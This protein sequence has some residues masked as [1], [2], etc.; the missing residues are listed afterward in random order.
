MQV[1]CSF[2]DHQ[3]TQLKWSRCINT[4]GFRGHNVSC[5][6]YLEHLNRTLKE[7]IRGLHSNISQEYQIML[8]DLLVLSIMYAKL[9]FSEAYIPR[10]WLTHQT[11]LYKGMLHIV[12]EL[13]QYKVFEDH[14]RKPRV[15]QRVKNVKQNCS[16][17]ELEAWILQKLSSYKL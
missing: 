9:Y 10:I 1:H 4:K 6:L 12:K 11:F 17:K 8:L 7:M 16:T 2:S 14:K 3:V 5:D 13:E 15:Y